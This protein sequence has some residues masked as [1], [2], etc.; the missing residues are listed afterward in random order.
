MSCPKPILI[1]FYYSICANR[2]FMLWAKNISPENIETREKNANRMK[3]AKKTRRNQNCVVFL[4][5]KK[6]VWIG[7]ISCME[8]NWCTHKHILKCL[9]CWTD[10]IGI[11][12]EE[13]RAF[14]ISHGNWRQQI[15][16]FMASELVQHRDNNK[17]RII[18][19]AFLLPKQFG[20]VEFGSFCG[21]SV[22]DFG[23]RL[24]CCDYFNLKK[25]KPHKTN[26]PIMTAK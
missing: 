23:I 20:C 24:H 19:H 26:S 1:G 15:I 6:V 9:V 2:T 7:K 12:R 17:T 4:F 10:S 8:S 21:E 18:S 22:N 25:S 14:R 5:G 11:S 16:K 3:S 13:E